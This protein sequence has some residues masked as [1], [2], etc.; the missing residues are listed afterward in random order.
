MRSLERMQRL[1]AFQSSRHW[2]NS[3]W[4]RLSNTIIGI[5]LA[6]SPGVL[7]TSG[8]AKTNSVIC[9]ILAASI[10]IIAIWEVTRGLRWLNTLIG[11]WLL[12][13]VFVFDYQSSG[14]LSGFLAGIAMIALSLARGTIRHATG[15]GWKSLLS[16][17]DR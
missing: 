11:S 16:T 17:P 8:L 14:M 10:S 3:M 12:I 4:A 1:R 6:A 2:G 5:W 7:G 9:G 13:S 15:G